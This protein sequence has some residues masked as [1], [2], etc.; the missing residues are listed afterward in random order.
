MSQLVLRER[1]CQWL[2]DPILGDQDVDTKIRL[3][4]EAEYMRRYAKYRQIDRALSQ[5]YGLTFQEF[6]ERRIVK[7]KGYTWEVETDAMNW[8]TAIGGMETM[9][10]KLRELRAEHALQQ[11]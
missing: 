1:T 6:V 4:I 10:R 3:L 11:A 7:D 8:E 2:Q 9:E 5:K